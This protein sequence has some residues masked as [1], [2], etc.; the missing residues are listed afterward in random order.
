MENTQIPDE[1]LEGL[2][3]RVHLRYIGDRHKG[4]F[5]KKKGRT[6]KY[7]DYQGTIIKDDEILARIKALVLPPAWSDVWICPY[8]N[9]HL[10]ATGIDAAGRK[11][12][13]YHDKWSVIKNQS[14]FN[15]LLDFGRQLPRLRKQLRKDL[16]RP[17]LDKQKAI[18]IAI[19]VMDDTFI[20]VGNTSYEQKYG[21][22]GLTTLKNRH[23][24]IKGQECFFRF[25]GKK[26]VVQKLSL[27]SKELIRLLRKIKEI[28]G[29]ALFQYYDEKDTVRQLESGD[30]NEYLK[31]YMGDEF[32]CKDFRTWAGTL[33]ALNYMKQTDNDRTANI[34]KGMD[35]SH[36]T[37]E[38]LDHVATEL[39]NTR[40]VTKKYYVHPGLLASYE[41]NELDRVVPNLVYC[42]PRALYKTG[43]KELLHFLKYLKKHKK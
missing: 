35:S 11:Q 13:R 23:I 26:G 33:L 43:E 22:Y 2:L 19:T 14:K 12:Y 36:A 30:I 16:K 21:S 25:R 32:T 9:G 18:A 7:I 5:R 42:R 6:F 17:G 40:A 31:T 41:A 1:Q 15:S 3:E 34:K 39:G 24:S 37:V 29:Q 4:Y 38:I 27:S 20:R 10:Q 28:P 8:H